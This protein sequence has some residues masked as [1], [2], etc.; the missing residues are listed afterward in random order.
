MGQ[1]FPL[2]DRRLLIA[3]TLIAFVAALSLAWYAF[4]IA[5]Q[6]PE[7]GEAR[8]IRAPEGPTKLKPLQPGGRTVPNQDVLV[9][10]VMETETDRKTPERLLPPHEEPME[11]PRSGS[12]DAEMAETESTPP[13]PRSTDWAVAESAAPDSAPAPEK[14][15]PTPKETIIEARPSATNPPAPP[16]RITPEPKKPPSETRPEASATKPPAPQPPATAAPEPPEAA[17]SLAEPPPPLVPKPGTHRVQLGAFTVKESASTHWNRLQKENAQLFKNL[18]ARFEAIE[19]GPDKKV[20]YRLRTDPL[21]EESRARSL[22]SALKGEN[23]DCI[24]VAP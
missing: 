23:I 12:P 6:A 20:L 9:F 3:T 19:I 24:V 5:G 16:E 1:K 13:T 18:R 14:T 7:T 22:C 4:Q 2:H 21:I 8:L 10:D 17:A 11:K 15:T